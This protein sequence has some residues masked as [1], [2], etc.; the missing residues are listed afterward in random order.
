M[1]RNPQDF[2]I[3][4]RPNLPDGLHQFSGFEKNPFGGF[5]PTRFPSLEGP[6]VE[7]VIITDSVDVAGASIGADMITEFQ[8]LA[9]WKTRKGVPCVIRTVEWIADNYSG[10]DRPEKIRNFV[11]DAS[12]Y[13]G[14]NYIL[15]GGD[16]DIVPSRFLG[17]PG[18]NLSNGLLKRA[19]PPAD[20]YYGELDQSWNEDP[21]AYYG[22]TIDDWVHPRWEFMDLWVGRIPARDA[23]EAGTIIDKVLTYERSPDA[24][25]ASPP[26]TSYYN[27]VLLVAGPTNCADGTG[28]NPVVFA[29]ETLVS[30]LQIS[31]F[32]TD[33][34]RLYCFPPDYET[35]CGAGGP[36]TR[37]YQGFYEYFEEVEECWPSGGPACSH[38][39]AENFR[40]ELAEGYGFVYHMEHSWRDKLGDIT[41]L[42]DKWTGCDSVS[43]RNECLDSLK[44]A[45][46]GWQ[47]DLH[48]DMVD[49]LQNG[50]EYSI[51]VSGGSY[52]NQWDLDAVGEHFVRAPSGG[53][54]AYFGKAA[55]HGDSNVPVREFLLN[56]FNRGLFH[57]GEATGQ[58]TNSTF[59]PLAYGI[60]WSLLGDPEM[61]LWTKAPDEMGVTITPRML[62]DLGARGRGSA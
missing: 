7:C 6:P 21:D 19:D 16:V 48:W 31:L 39:T 59:A 58:A 35:Y 13:W 36:L 43:W 10:A 25:A 30:N 17:G 12:T 33:I 11:V 57:L 46:P 3:F 9:D 1:V 2:D 55:S 24:P 34:K 5:R 29:E 23:A 26:D 40:M 54:V 62:T 50:P 32:H 18:S 44:A 61:P 28:A 27:D 8:R 45:N 38:F 22:E 15:L 47:G 4:Y 56:V 37:C 51:V 41:P 60:N 52:T 49:H 53:A 42:E 14:T 20:I